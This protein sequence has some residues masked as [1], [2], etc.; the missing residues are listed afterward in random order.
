[1]YHYP[2]AKCDVQLD[3]PEACEVVTD[4][5]VSTVCQLTRND[6]TSIYSS[7]TAMTVFLILFR[8]GVLYALCINASRVLHNRMFNSVLRA[9]VLFFDSNPSG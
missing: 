3:Q 2:R 5:N 9:P 8:A 6:R 7:I 4:A 1:M